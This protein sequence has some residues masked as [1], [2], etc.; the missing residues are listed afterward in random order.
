MLSVCVCVP[1]EVHGGISLRLVGSQG[2]VDVLQVLLIREFWDSTGQHLDT[3]N[4]LLSTEIMCWSKPTHTHI[5]AVK[6]T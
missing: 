2:I 5:R 4:H 1:G 6:Q 3:F